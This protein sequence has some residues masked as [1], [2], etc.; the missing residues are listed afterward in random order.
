MGRRAAPAPLLSGK[1]AVFRGSAFRERQDGPLE[2]DGLASASCRLCKSGGEESFRCMKMETFRADLHMHTHHSIDSLAKVEDVL[3]AAVKKGLSAIAITDH[4]ESAGALEAQKIARKKKLPLQV[5]IGEEVMSREGDLL[6]YFLKR[7][8]APGPLADVLKE[9]KKQGAVCSSAHP[10]DFKRSGIKVE[11]LPASLLKQIDAIEGFNAR[12]TFRGI[13]DSAMKFA[14]LHKKPVLAGSD[15]HHPLEVGGAYAE[16]E[17]VAKLD[18]R[19][20]LSAPRTLHG[21]LSS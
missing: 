18:A 9:V 13:N 16:F 12:A 7:R 4:N 2:R 14:L 6:V 11:K 1:I 5:I 10:Y 3:L 21:R 20:I 17:G 19:N 15:A 8:I